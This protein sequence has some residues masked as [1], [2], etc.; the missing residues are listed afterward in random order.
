MQKYAREANGG[1][2]IEW[3][4]GQVEVDTSPLNKY[5]LVEQHQGGTTSRWTIKVGDIVRDH[6]DSSFGKRK[7]SALSHSNNKKAKKQC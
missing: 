6:E 3:I 4:T 7:G 2:K 1:E 5:I